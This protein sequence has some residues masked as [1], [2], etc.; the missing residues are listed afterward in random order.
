MESRK[1]RILLKLIRTC[2]LVNLVI[3]NIV[4]VPI[5]MHI[6]LIISKII[7]RYAKNYC[8]NKIKI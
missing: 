3:I 6:H 8:R 4:Y 2:N 1:F 5:F 7:I